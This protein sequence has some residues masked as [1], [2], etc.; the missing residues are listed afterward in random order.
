MH[1]AKKT[2]DVL[3]VDLSHFF[4]FSFTIGPGLAWLSATI[5]SVILVI[6]CYYTRTGL[7][8]GRTDGRMDGQT[9]ERRSIST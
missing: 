4:F 9:G 1:I 2:T 6:Y 7:E 8:D 5:T 3:M